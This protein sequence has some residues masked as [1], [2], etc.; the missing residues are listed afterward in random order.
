VLGYGVD[1]KNAPVFILKRI[2]GLGEEVLADI[3]IDAFC[4]LGA[5]DLDVGKLAGVGERL[6]TACRVGERHGLRDA[7]CH[8]E[9]LYPVAVMTPPWTHE[10]RQ[11]RVAEVMGDLLA[12]ER[13]EAALV[14]QAQAQNLP[15]G[16]YN[17]CSSL[18]ILQWRLV[19]APGGRLD[20]AKVCF[21]AW[22]PGPPVAASFS[23][24]PPRA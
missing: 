19:T 8:A 20:E 10:M 22:A 1:Q 9:S 17:D 12:V 13:D 24:M 18:A 5:I 15:V 4:Q 16:H 11:Q 2:H 14:W 7:P 6:R 21:V 23:K 3:G